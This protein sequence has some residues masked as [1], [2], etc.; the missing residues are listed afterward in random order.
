MADHVESALSGK[1]IFVSRSRDEAAKLCEALE[2]Q[3]ARVLDSALLHFALPEDTAPMDAALKSL[4][5]FDWW[6]LT[7][8]HA[9][10]F[11]AVRCRALH[12]S[13]TELVK[14]VRIG[15]VGQATAQAAVD[16]GLAVEYTAKQPS[17]A[18]LAREIA[19][20][21]AGKRVLL[22]RSNLADSALPAGLAEKGAEVTDVIGYRTLPPG[23]NEKNR[24]AVMEWE[25]VD[26]AVFSSPSA[27]RY[28]AEAIGEERMKA[29]VDRTVAVAVG[30]STAEAAR[31]QG[32]AQCVIAEQPSAAAIARALAEYF[33][34]RQP[35]KMTGVH[36]G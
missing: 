30:P 18:G 7:S 9:V 16:Q 35:R 15:A 12:L 21:L 11:A 6:L 26:A 19:E 3:G 2:S 29:A 27:I 10:E 33:E 31:R 1:L 8:Q 28:W 36:P 24:L 20:R 5:D 32:F 4:A 17:A 23:L 14:R 34:D 22:L 13:L 25:K